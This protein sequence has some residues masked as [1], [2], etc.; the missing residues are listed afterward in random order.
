MFFVFT[1]YY[2]FIFFNSVSLIQSFYYQIF[3]VPPNCLNAKQLVVQLCNLRQAKKNASG[4]G[5]QLRFLHD[6]HSL[7][8][9]KIWKIIKQL[10]SSQFT[11]S[12]LVRFQFQLT[13]LLLSH[14]IVFIFQIHIHGLD[15]KDSKQFSDLV[16]TSA[17]Q[18]W[19]EELSHWFLQLIDQFA[20]VF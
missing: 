16:V 4:Q 6:L 13:V 7:F 17:D 3:I 1:G 10:Q 12:L 9:V 5:T 15:F 19:F 11:L 2:C 8:Q 18:N 14:R 20:N